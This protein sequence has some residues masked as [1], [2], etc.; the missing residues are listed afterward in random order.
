MRNGNGNNYNFQMTPIIST[1]PWHPHPNKSALV[2]ITTSGLLKMF[3]GQNNGTVHETTLELESMTLEDDLISHASVCS[4]RSKL[5]RTIQSS[6]WFANEI[7]KTLMIAMVTK[8]KQLRVVQVGINWGIPKNDGAQN[9]PPGS[10]QL[11]PTLTKR[12]V[13]VTSW[14]QP[15][16]TGSHLDAATPKI[17]HVE[18]LPTILNGTTKEWSSPGILTVRSFVPEPN[19]PYTQEVQSIIDRWELLTDE[20]QTIHPAFEQLGARRNTVGTVPPVRITYAYLIITAN[21]Y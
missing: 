7:A 9:V 12:H 19:S 16:S 3:W 11:N 15:G 4:D 10:H 17:T 2:C 14:F 8:S 5:P 6:V 20:P 1:G 21:I 18:M 13:A